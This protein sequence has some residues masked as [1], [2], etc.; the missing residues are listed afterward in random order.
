MIIT[1][2]VARNAKD[3]LISNDSVLAPVITEVGLCTIRPQTNY[4]GSLVDSIISQQLS[5]HA[6]AAIEK[7]FRD[8][9]NSVDFPP[10][11]KVLEKNVEELRQVGVGRMKAN[12]IRDLAQNVVD[13]KLKFD[14]FN[15]LSNEEIIKQLTVVKGIG[16]WTAQM[17]LMFCIARSDILPTGDL[18]IKNGINRLY[19][20][21][22]L[23][24]PEQIRAVADKYNWHPYESIASWY[25]WQ[26]LR[27]TPKI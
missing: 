25:V 5:T 24:D 17:F 16:E 12:Y 21:P 6:A 13:G 20:T 8:L 2:S 22:V 10:A 15:T 9:F 27:N 26:Y 1:S 11:E 19:N 18:G 3:Y 7:R 14:N 23:P 4:Y